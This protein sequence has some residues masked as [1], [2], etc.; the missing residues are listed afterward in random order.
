MVCNL[1]WL[2]ANNLHN[3]VLT[4]YDQEITIMFLIF[5]PLFLFDLCYNFTTSTCYIIHYYVIIYFLMKH[6]DITKIILYWFPFLKIVVF[7]SI[8]YYVS[9]IKIK[10]HKLSSSTLFGDYILREFHI[11]LVKQCF[12]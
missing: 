4:K 7:S 11:W 9:N 2:V 6:L 1:V 3:I 10:H 12:C 8:Y 5:D